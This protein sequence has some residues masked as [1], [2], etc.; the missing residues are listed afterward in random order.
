MLEILIAILAISYL[1]LAC[2]RLDWAVLMIIFGLP[3]YLLRF[4]AFGVP[5]TILETMILI[6]FVV[7]WVKLFWPLKFNFLKYLKNRDQHL[8]Y[9]FKYEII[10][11]SLQT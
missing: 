8:A 7:W 9:P 11:L 10:L 6:S 5:I 4:S 2:Y 1:I 3:T